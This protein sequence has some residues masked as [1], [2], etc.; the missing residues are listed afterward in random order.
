MIER[1]CSM[2]TNLLLALEEVMAAKLETTTLRTNSISPIQFRSLY[3]SRLPS[4]MAIVMGM[5][6]P[7]LWMHTLMIS[8]A[9]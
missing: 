3:Q 6:S 9:L 8:L 4:K 5:V 7:I 1:V 2:T